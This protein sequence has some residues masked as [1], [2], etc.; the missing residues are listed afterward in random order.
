M[1]VTRQRTVV[2]N[3]AASKTLPLELAPLGIQDEWS[4]VVGSA[5]DDAVEMHAFGQK[6]Q[7]CMLAT[8]C[9]LFC[10]VPYAMYKGTRMEREFVRKMTER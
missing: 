10:T 9:F 5:V 6:L 3:E 7:C 8:A 4:H 1:S 2:I